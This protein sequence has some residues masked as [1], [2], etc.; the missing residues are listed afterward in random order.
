[1]SSLLQLERQQKDFF[2]SYSFIIETTNTFIHY[3][4]CLV[5]HARFQTKMG[6]IYRFQAKMAPKPYPFGGKGKYLLTFA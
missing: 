3:R 6:K 1:M 2:L 5:N 4:S